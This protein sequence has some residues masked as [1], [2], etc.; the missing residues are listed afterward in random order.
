ME[1]PLKPILLSGAAKKYTLRVYEEV[2]FN[3][4]SVVSI[5]PERDGSKQS[6]N[7]FNHSQNF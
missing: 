2:S 3:R 4:N 7:D 5:S 1:L 6:G